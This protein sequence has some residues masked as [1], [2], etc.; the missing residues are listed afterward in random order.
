MI[1]LVDVVTIITLKAFIYLHVTF[2]LF[3]CCDLLLLNLNYY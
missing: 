3:R 2:L 1:I